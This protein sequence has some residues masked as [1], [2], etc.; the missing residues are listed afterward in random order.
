M[1]Q[2]RHKELKGRCLCGAVCFELHPPLRDVIV[3]HCRQCAQWTGY[4]VAATAVAMENFTLTGGSDVLKWYA[5]SDHAD[6]GFC[7][8]CGSSLFWRP[9]DGTRMSVLAGSLDPPTGLKVGAHI[10]TADKS[11]YYRISDEAQQ[12]PTGAGASAAVPASQ[13]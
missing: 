3:C 9:S 1:T 10:F 8:T 11:D 6:R 2:V 5:S 13:G 4:A 7:G 12:F